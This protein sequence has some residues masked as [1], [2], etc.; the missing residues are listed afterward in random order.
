M[1]VI[2][3]S[4][5]TEDE[6]AALGAAYREARDSIAAHLRVQ[7]EA[8]VAAGAVRRRLRGLSASELFD[9][10]TGDAIHPDLIAA[11]GAVA[12]AAADVDWCRAVTVAC[13]E[14]LKGEPLL[15]VLERNRQNRAAA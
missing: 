14:A 6:Q 12:A 3:G 8:E 11:E 15:V 1:T 5:L 9:R 7:A 10:E 2:A 4:T 13:A